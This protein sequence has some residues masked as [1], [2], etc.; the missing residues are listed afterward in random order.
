MTDPTGLLPQQ[1]MHSDVLV[2]SV[3]WFIEPYWSGDRLLASLNDGRV[4]M[5]DARG[6]R[7]DEEFIEA[8]ALLADAI[9]A[10]AAVVDGIWT[11]QPDVGNGA[12]L[13]RRAA[14]IKAG[15]FYEAPDPIEVAER[16][17]FVAID[18]VELEG[19]SL[20]EVP[21]QERRRLLESV[22]RAR[23]RVR[24]SPAVR[25]PFRPWLDAWRNDGFVSYVAKHVNSRY[26]PG[27][28]AQAWHVLSVVAEKVPSMAGRLIGERA[29]KRRRIAD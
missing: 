10:D 28:T 12:V 3:D 8:A 6:D 23:G 16:P 4:S 9:D 5:T 21:Y 17:A 22:V 7:V 1:A 15:L 25:L 24:L 19:I 27:Q 11:A 26:H 14:M 2:E 18:L 20:Q 13:R 29:R